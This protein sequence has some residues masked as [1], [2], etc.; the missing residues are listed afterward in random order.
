MISRK[1]T[2]T[3]S[4]LGSFFTRPSQEATATKPW[5]NALGRVIPRSFSEG[6]SASEGVA[7]PPRGWGSTRLMSKKVQFFLIALVLGSG[8]LWET[9]L[10]PS[11]QLSFVLL[12]S[13]LA[14]IS[15]AVVLRYDLAGIE[16]L[17]LLILPSFFTLAIGAI[18]AFFPNF[19]LTFRTL[20]LG[21]YAFSFYLMLLAENIFNVGRER[22]IPL[23]KAASTVSF[24]LTLLTAFLLFTALYKAAF[25]I[26]LQWFLLFLIVFL[27]A[28]QSLWTV[29]LG[30]KLETRL[31]WA[32]GF[33]ALGLLEL[34]VVLSF[35][36]LE[37]FFRALALSTGFY[38]FLGIAFHYF[39]R[40]LG[41]QVFLE[42]A[43]VVALV[44]LILAI[45]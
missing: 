5:I 9:G 7:Q 45:L 35:L 2:P 31:L 27:L 44:V 25:P 38:V 6:G 8:F 13:V 42:Y 15:A 30:I 17:T 43:A 16:F 22:P 14:Y 41:S 12:W 32:S 34:A 40:T 28:F 26:F 33:L 4:F 21:L 1:S 37:S 29:V 3:I 23:L 19:S 10:S 20:I 18:L 11:S 24:L 39:K 36:P